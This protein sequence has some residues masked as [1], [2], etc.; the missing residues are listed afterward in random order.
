MADISLHTYK[1]GESLSALNAAHKYRIS[2]ENRLD[3]T[4]ILR[5]WQIDKKKVL[6]KLIIAIKEQIGDD[7]TFALAVAPSTTEYFVNDIKAQLQSVFKNSIDI[8]DCFSK[9]NGFAAT[10]VNHVLSD[11]ELR[12]NYFL[13][14]D[15][16]KTKITDEVKQILLVDDVYSLGNTFNGMKL[17]ISDIDTTKEI[18]TAVILKTA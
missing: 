17:A 16:Y 7:A 14:N 4:D 5:I 10:T 3:T 8:S 13:N 11:S 1:Q 12:E 6:N 18:I 15:C 2:R 9:N